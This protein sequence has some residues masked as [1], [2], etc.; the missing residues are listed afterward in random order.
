MIVSAPRLPSIT[1]LGN[2]SSTNTSGDV[3]SAL[4]T[5]NSGFNDAAADHD[6][7]IATVGLDHRA[8]AQIADNEMESAPSVEVSNRKP[9]PPKMVAPLAT[10]A[11]IDGVVAEVTGQVRARDGRQRID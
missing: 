3:V 11:N 6:G 8:G 10:L 5:V 7:V 1:E 4:T 9:P 2:R